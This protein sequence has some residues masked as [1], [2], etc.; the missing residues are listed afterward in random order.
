MKLLIDIPQETYEFL[1]NSKENLYWNRGAIVSIINGTPIPDNIT[2]EGLLL[3]FFKDE[4]LVNAITSSTRDFLMYKP[5]EDKWVS[6]FDAPYDTCG[7]WKKHEMT[8]EEF[9]DAFNSMFTY[10]EST[11]KVESEE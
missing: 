11:N 4:R 2:N 3:A 9:L 7:K 10:K 1:K 6:W 8:T 5:T